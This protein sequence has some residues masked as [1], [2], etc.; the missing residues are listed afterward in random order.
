MLDC[1][2]LDAAITEGAESA[3]SFLERLVAEPST[4]GNEAGALEVF[5]S[6]LADLGFEVR[7]VEVSREIG[8][9]PRAGISPQL[10][11]DRY[12][13]VGSMGSGPGRSL[14]LNGHIDV[15]PADSP[16]S[17]T[18]PPFVPR[19]EGPFMFGRGAG[20][21]KC[22]FAM[23]VL[24]LRALLAVDPE[25]I[26]G[27][28]TFLAVIEEEC[29]GNGALSSARDGILAD[30]AIL[31]EPTDLNLLVGGLGV[32][33]CDIEVDGVSAHAHAAHEATNPV[34][35]L[36]RL[37][38]GLRVWAAGLET[39]HPDPKM[40]E[41]TSP[42][43]L[44][45]GEI[46]AGDWPSSVP[47][48]ATMRLRIGFPRA[49]T[50]DDAEHEVRAAVATIVEAD[51]GF[52]TAP[53]IRPSGFRARGYH[54][55]PA[56]PLVVDLGRA[57]AHAHGIR[58]LAYSLGSTTDA[59]WYVND[60]D[61]PAVCFGPIAHSIHGVDEHVELD[62]IVQGARTLARFLA[63]WYK[64]GSLTGGGES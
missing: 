25:A 26:A 35:L 37:L 34:D 23:G 47:T 2:A 16:A 14:L 59:R 50:P 5:A 42:Y 17:W 41:V 58:P 6:E 56:D 32:L 43:N 24:A 57:H 30:A 1:A 49:W 19:R 33:W 48:T 3:F 61:V 27:P 63:D 13:V 8:S 21:M 60:F 12:Q 40:P 53:R 10:D 4:V 45:L 29:S 44:N 22:G 28:L 36:M 9:D 55:D 15:V 11:A 7:R 39:S 31:L 18:S 51:G 52:P 38:A 46:H 20:D 54:L 62:S 64:P